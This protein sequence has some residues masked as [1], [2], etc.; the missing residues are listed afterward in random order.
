M[1]AIHTVSAWPVLNTSINS[2]MKSPDDKQ[3]PIVIIWSKKEA[4]R[5]I[6]LHPASF[7]LCFH[8]AS[9]GLCFHPA[10]FG[11]CF[12]SAGFGLWWFHP[13]SLG[14]FWLWF[15]PASVGI[16][17]HPASFGVLQHPAS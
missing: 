15:H 13:A 11:L 16:L 12:H 10:S 7:G 3:T 17:F 6:Q 4:T 5:T 1:E 9:F 14:P 8:P 2:T